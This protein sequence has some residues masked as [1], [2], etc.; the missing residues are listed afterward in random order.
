MNVL[1]LI[2]TTINYNING[3]ITMHIY[4]FIKTERN[5]KYNVLHLNSRENRILK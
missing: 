4:K 3:Y 2:N 1:F 5:I